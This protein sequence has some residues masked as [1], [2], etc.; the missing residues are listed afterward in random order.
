MYRLLIISNTI[1]DDGTSQ[2]QGTD[3]VHEEIVAVDSHYT[4]LDKPESSGKAQLSNE[5]INLLKDASGE[6]MIKRFQDFPIII[7]Y[8][9]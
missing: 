7:G 6:M 4:R 9:N 5:A 3:V 2:L 1:E 8:K